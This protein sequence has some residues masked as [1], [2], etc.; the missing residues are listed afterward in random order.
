MRLFGRIIN[1]LMAFIGIQLVWIVVLVFWISWFMRSHRKLRTLAEKYSPELLQGGT[2][3]FILIEGIVLLAAILVGVY[4]IFLYWQR[5]NA[6]N[7]ARHQFVA[8]VTHELKSP[9]ASLQLHLE[10]I[11][12][13]QPVAEKLAD[14]V[15]TMLS[16]TRRLDMLT[17]NLLTANRLEHKGLKL[18]L[19]PANFS[20]LVEKYFRDQQYSLPRAGR[21]ELN[22]APGLLVNLDSDSLETVFRNLLEN[23]LLYS[24]GPPMIRVSLQA[25]GSY[26][27]L[28]F[29]DQGRGMEHADQKKVFQMFYRVRI[30]GKTIRGSG[31]GLFIV[32]GVVKLHKGRVWVESPGLGAGTSVH[33]MLPL[34][35]QSTLESPA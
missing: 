3:W 6:L 17:S 35:D 19:L 33:I 2:E 1:P 7:R 26:A 18:S 30:P 9:I 20:K 5:Q 22:I 31:L 29:S 12:R 14:F 24:D 10:T 32:R 13:R 28:V 25:E 8:Q 15:N 4:V 16:D 34:S 21:M 23:A 11:R 27:H